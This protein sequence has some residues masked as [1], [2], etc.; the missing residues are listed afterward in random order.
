[1]QFARDRNVEERADVMKEI[2]DKFGYMSVD[3]RQKKTKSNYGGKFKN[4]F[5]NVSPVN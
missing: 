4:C 5:V 2:R 1:M 3:I